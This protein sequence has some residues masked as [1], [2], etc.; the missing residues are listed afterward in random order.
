MAVVI[1]F[2][3]V[4]SK[5]SGMV[6]ITGSK[7]S[8]T[9]AGLFSAYCEELC[10]VSCT[11]WRCPKNEEMTKIHPKLYTTMFAL[12]NILPRVF[13]IPDGWHSDW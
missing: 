2:C 6:V 5:T 3:F 7:S 11:T 8:R 9:S 1:R 10:D 12:M 4:N 13:R